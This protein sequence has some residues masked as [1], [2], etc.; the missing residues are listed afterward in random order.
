MVTVYRGAEG[1]CWRRLPV[2]PVLLL[3]G[4]LL[5]GGR[6]PYSK[7]PLVGPSCKPLDTAGTAASRHFCTRSTRQSSHAGIM[8]T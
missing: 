1:N 5:N 8:D 4:R 3:L 6:P 7:V 2:R